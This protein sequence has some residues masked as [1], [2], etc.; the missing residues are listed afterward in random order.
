MKFSTVNLIRAVLICSVGVVE[1]DVD[2]VAAAND[3]AYDAKVASKKD[4][5]V[6]SRLCFSQCNA[7]RCYSYSYEKFSINS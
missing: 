2:S 1:S 7:D 5:A 6:S 3:I 4:T